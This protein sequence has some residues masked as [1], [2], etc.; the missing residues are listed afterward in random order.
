MIALLVDEQ[1]MYKIAREQGIE[2][3]DQA[4]KPKKIDMEL[5]KMSDSLKD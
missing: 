5:L 4:R 3:G 2:C 1:Y